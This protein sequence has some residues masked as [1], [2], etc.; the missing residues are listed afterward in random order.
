MPIAPQRVSED[1]EGWREISKE[2]KTN[3]LANKGQRAETIRNRRFQGEVRIWPACGKGRLQSKPGKN[4]SC[5]RPLIRAI[6]TLRE[7]KA[8]Y[9]RA[10]KRSGRVNA[11]SSVKKTPTAKRKNSEHC[12]RNSKRK[13]LLRDHSKD[14]ALGAISG[15]GVRERKR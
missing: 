2:E 10:G 5:S 7:K 4:E 13:D 11:E 8:W 1:L 9:F 12:L 14:C 15:E 3:R 6:A